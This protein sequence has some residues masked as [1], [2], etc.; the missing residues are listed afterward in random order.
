MMLFLFFCFVFFYE[1]EESIV[2]VNDSKFNEYAVQVTLKNNVI[3]SDTLY[4]SE[5]IVL[6]ILVE[7]DYEIQT[8]RLTKFGE[9]KK[10]PNTYQKINTSRKAK[11]RLEE[12]KML[13]L[14]LFPQDIP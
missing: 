13:T 5:S 10:I 4:P 1:Q 8:K 2:F 3:L 9:Y 6:P 7:T 12:N 11:I 14:H